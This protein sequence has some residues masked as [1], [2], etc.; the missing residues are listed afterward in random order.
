MSKSYLEITLI[1]PTF[2]RPL[3][4]LKTLKSINNLS[5][6]PSEVIIVDQSS[7]ADQIN[8][9]ILKKETPFLRI[10]LIKEKIPSSTKARNIGLN[11]AKN[12]IIVFSDDDVDYNNEVFKIIDNEFLSDNRLSLIAAYDQDHRFKLSSLFGIILLRR[13][14]FKLFSGHI[15]KSIFGNFP[16]IKIRT[17]T[18]WAMGFFFSIR[19]KIAIQ[20]NNYFDENFSGYSYAEDL[21]F[22]YNYINEA[23]KK[24][25]KALLIPTIKVKHLVS[26]EYRIL[27]S[28]YYFMYLN[29]R[30]YILKKYHESSKF[31]LLIFNTANF[32]FLIYLYFK[33][34]KNFNNYLK[35]LKNFKK[36]ISYKE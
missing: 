23:K 19:K 31:H 34:N 24:G 32:L 17:N 10:N 13:S 5:F 11:Q 2:N 21:D 9:K 25:Y 28:S 16:I 18:S 35:A 3:S 30:Y 22:S 33:N 20:N 29:N 12:D 26:N 15:S 6:L 27:D 8:L 4:L 7:N 1:I 14:I 36:T